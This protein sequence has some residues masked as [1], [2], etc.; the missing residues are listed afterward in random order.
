MFGSF[1]GTLNCG[2]SWFDKLMGHMCI[3][4]T[5]ELALSVQDGRVLHITH[6]Q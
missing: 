2:L 5:A 6:Y 1:R 4:G 3:G